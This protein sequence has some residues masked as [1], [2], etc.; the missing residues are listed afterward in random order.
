MEDWKFKAKD[1]LRDYMA[2]KNAVNSL[3]HEIRRL[4]EEAVSI[5]AATTDST[6]VQG[7]G[8]THE[9]RILSNIVYRQ[10]AESMLKRAKLAV[11]FV[12]AAL[13]QLS[14]D[15]R[16]VLELMYIDRQRGAINRLREELCL[17]DERS[18]YKRADKALKH[19]TIAMYG[20]TES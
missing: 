13:A 8:S 9:D 6:P 16:R 14:D 12:D 19:L 2:Q 11:Q 18:V 4:E 3:P 7:G 5:K 17:E 20:A 10:E 1:K 15:E